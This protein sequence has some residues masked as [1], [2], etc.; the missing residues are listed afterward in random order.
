MKHSQSQFHSI[1]FSQWRANATLLRE[2]FFGSEAR[3]P[4]TIRPDKY[5]VLE[6]HFTQ[7]RPSQKTNKLVPSPFPPNKVLSALGSCKLLFPRFVTSSVYAS[8]AVVSGSC[9]LS[10]RPCCCW[11]QT[12]PQPWPRLCQATSTNSTNVHPPCDNDVDLE[13]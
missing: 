9:T 7:R 11:P 8:A 1:D 13:V 6:L 3:Y 4:Q 5:R 10:A 12:P 2:H